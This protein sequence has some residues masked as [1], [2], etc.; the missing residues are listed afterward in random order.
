MPASRL[1]SHRGKESERTSQIFREK[2]ESRPLTGNLHCSGSPKSQRR[3]P[4]KTSCKASSSKSR[5]SSRKSPRQETR[6][7]KRTPKTT[8]RRADSDFTPRILSIPLRRRIVIWCSQPVA[9]QLGSLTL[10]RLRK[11]EPRTQTPWQ[12]QEPLN[13]SNRACVRSLRWC[14]ACELDKGSRTRTASQVRHRKRQPRPCSNNGRTSSLC[15]H[16][17]AR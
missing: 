7:T 17:S 5:S 9:H 13:F 14:Q 10:P 3:T 1:D 16:S 15:N 8:L 11:P 4:R 12:A 2:R 6:N